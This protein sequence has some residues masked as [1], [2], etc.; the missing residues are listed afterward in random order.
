MV[1]SYSKKGGKMNA[2]CR[3]HKK[4]IVENRYEA[5]ILNHAS[6]I[7]PVAYLILIILVGI[8]ITTILGQVCATESNIYYYHMGDL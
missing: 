4:P 2:P 1:T 6:I 8:L 7:V 5:W 3:L